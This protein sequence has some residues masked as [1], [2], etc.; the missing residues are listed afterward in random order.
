M[1]S[2]RL[3]EPLNKEILQ[4]RSATMWRYKELLPVLE[5][6]NIVSLG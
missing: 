5:E 1:A 2:Y 6:G 3:Q 4:N